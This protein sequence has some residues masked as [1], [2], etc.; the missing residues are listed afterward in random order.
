MRKSNNSRLIAEWLSS[1]LSRYAYSG[2]LRNNEKFIKT[3]L[4]VDQLWLNLIPIY[5]DNIIICKDETLNLGHWN[6]YQGNLS[7]SNGR[8]FFDD[9]PVI[10][11]HFSNIP[12]D[13]PEIVSRHSSLY[14]D[15][16]VRVWA[17]LYSDYAKRLLG[18]KEL[19]GLLEY[20]FLNNFKT[21]EMITELH[22]PVDTLPDLLTET[23]PFTFN[24]FV[25]K[26]IM[27]MSSKMKSP[28]NLE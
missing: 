15:S 9:R 5:F 14:I 2:L 1:R 24:T 23:Q 10:I 28:T 21:D 11:T 25:R 20:T 26:L 19:V 18:N 16:P 8:Y 3:N 12:E 6:L 27:K 13:N 4:F 17:I 7:T 22:K